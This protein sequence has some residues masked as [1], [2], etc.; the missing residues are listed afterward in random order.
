LQQHTAV[1]ITVEDAELIVRLIA[2]GRS[3]T[4][5]V[6]TSGRWLPDAP[7]ANVIAE[8]VGSEK[9]EEIVVIGGHL[10]SWDVGQGAHDDGTG[11]VIMME[12][13][14]LLRKAGLRPRRTIRVVLFTN[15]ENGGRGSK[16]YAADHAAELPNHIAGLESDGGGFAPRGIEVSG[17][18]LA[19]THMQD[20]TTL[21]APLG[22]ARARAGYAGAD[23]EP[24]EKA[25][26]VGLGHWV[27]E[28][29]YFD[30]HHTAA[31]TLDKVDPVDLAR[32]VAAAAVVAFVVADMPERLGR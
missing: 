23:I 1:A 28:T 27:D 29:R 19:L 10:D 32:N 18:E 11:C 31:D 12:A 26:V 21:L 22:A 6:R 5:N 15:E 20:I 14:T 24:L 17:S 3:V 4:V 30:Y 25:G 16:A 8:L 9:P 7:S 13:L 2:A